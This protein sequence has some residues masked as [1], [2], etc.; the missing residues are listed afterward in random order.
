MKH[1]SKMIDK[2]GFG[3]E[4]YTAWNNNLDLLFFL[5]RI[6]DSQLSFDWKNNDGITPLMIASLRGKIDMVEA[7]VGVVDVNM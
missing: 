3:I 4:H 7:L 6:Q 1:I 5:F 2:S